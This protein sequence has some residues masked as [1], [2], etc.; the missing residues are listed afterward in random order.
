MRLI[1]ADDFR[2]YCQKIA[3]EEK[4]NKVRVSWSFAIDIFCDEINE[5]PTIDAVPVVRC[6]D[7]L[8]YDPSQ[9][10]I[11]INGLHC[12]LCTVTGS[13]MPEDGFCS[14]ARRRDKEK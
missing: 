12:G 1:D 10:C 11:G 2:E 6:R 3:C 4:D 5:R 9:W 13:D 7:C 14:Y 8:S